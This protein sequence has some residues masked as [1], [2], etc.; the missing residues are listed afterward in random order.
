[1]SVEVPRGFRVGGVHCGL[2]RNPQ[3]LD[4]TL[5][6]CD[7]PTISAGVYTQNVIRAAPVEWDSARTPNETTRAVVINSGNANACTG[8]RGL[9]DARRMA[10]LT[11]ATCGAAADEVLVMSTGIIGE[12]L[13]M[14]KIERGI[15][16]VADALGP[17]AENLEAA[18]RGILTTDTVTKIS[19][20]SIQCGDREFNVCGFAK[21]AAMIGPN[22]A[23]MLALLM[24]DAPLAAA[25][26]QSLLA[27][28]TDE[29]FNCIH[30]EGHTST[31]DTVLLLA[32]SAAGG[33]RLG[34]AELA[35]FRD[36]LLEVCTELARA[37]PADGEGT[38]H[39]IEIRVR[40]CADVASAKQIAR[41]IANS[42]LVKTAVAGA[43]PNW[44]R[45]VSAAG[46]AGVAF[47]PQAITLR[48][49]G[50]LLYQN[51]APVKFDAASVSQSMRDRSEVLIE[52]QFADGDSDTK[53]WTTDL[54]AEYVRLNAD[55]HT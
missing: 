14:E 32:S 3:K 48:L 52:L 21:G 9:D 11:A 51:G 53:F 42:P 27:S 35:G 2:K 18:A 33:D 7:Q 29:T 47:D 45:I 41:T 54:T 5:V 10:E 55:Y 30:V 49:N 36:T 40:G 28:I 34:G 4:L 12:F 16:A 1:M 44:G 26:A 23:T 17:T 19:G 25:D 13:P 50:T 24:T 31:N 6:V 38:E 37:I 22:M 8:Q 15:A 43:D 20:R 39:L 46:Y